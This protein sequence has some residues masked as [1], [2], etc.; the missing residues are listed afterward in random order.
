MLD[1]N[2]IDTV[3]LDMDGTLLDLNYDYHFWLNHLPIRYAEEKSCSIEAAKEKIMG[4]ITSLQGSLNWYCLDYWSE[5]IDM[6]I[7]KVKAE[8]AHLINER[9]HCIAFLRWL[10]TEGKRT[11]LVTN[12]HQAGVDLKFKHSNIEPYLD[13]IYTS[14][15]FKEP[16]ESIRFWELFSQTCP[17][18]L[19]RS[20]L[21]DDNETVLQTA[22]TFGIQQVLTI[23][24]PNMQHPAKEAFQFPAVTCYQQLMQSD[25]EDS[26]A[27]AP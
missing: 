15:Q 3:L 27:G 20:V 25:A 6:D 12:S 8:V 5:Q 17:F 19:D 4:M 7:P 24:Q 21:I 11:V 26:E 18:D 13:E 22:Q 23:A 16:K 14:H 2:T 10:K 9:P 1:W